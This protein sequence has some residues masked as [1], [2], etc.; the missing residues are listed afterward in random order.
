[1]HKKTSKPRN[2]AVRFNVVHNEFCTSHNSFALGKCCRSTFKKEYSDSYQRDHIVG[3]DPSKERLHCVFQVLGHLLYLG[4]EV[5]EELGHVLLLARVQGLLVHGVGLTERT[6]VVRLP[7]ALLEP[8]TERG[9]ELA[10]GRKVERSKI[11]VAVSLRG[12]CLVV[13]VNGLRR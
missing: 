10:N 2:R 7:L 5:G 3:D 11:E 1:M 12:Q 4:D 13:L 8:G 9:E 6:G